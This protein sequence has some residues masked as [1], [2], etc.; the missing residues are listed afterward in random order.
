MTWPASPEWLLELQ[1]RFGQ[2]LRTPLERESG[3]L[4]APTELYDRA[5]VAATKPPPGSAAAERLAVYQR[6]YWF[7]LLGVLQ[8]AYPLTARLLGFWHFNG[9]AA[10]HL[11]RRAPGGFDIE[12]V[13]AGFEDLVAEELSG[14]ATLAI[15]PRGSIETAALLEAARVDSAFHRVF[16]APA[17]PAFRPGPDDLPRLARSRLALSHSVALI[18]ERWPLCEL[19]ASLL[20]GQ[21][22]RPV[23]LPAPLPRPRSTL[24]VRQGLQL[25]LVPLEPREAELL[26]LLTRHSL[27]DALGLLES[28]TP[29]D[30]LGAL[31][32]RAEAW[33]AKSVRLGAWR[34]FA[35]DEPESEDASPELPRG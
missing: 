6:Q 11:R 15:E 31:P 4:R 22:E 7:R 26:Q 1:Q 25:G 24:L 5:L 19:R 32:A 13:A 8:R 3:T 28:S 27:V 16:R 35:E 30:E 9:L 23:A 2:L 18:Q 10:E 12:L 14:R 21:D 29:P 17:A 33:L 34:G 20:D